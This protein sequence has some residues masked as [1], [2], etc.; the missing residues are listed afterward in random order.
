MKATL[1]K[2]AMAI[3]IA[4]APMF[5]HAQNWSMGGN[6]ISGG[7]SQSSPVWKLGVNSGPGG[8]RLDIVH[9][10]TPRIRVQTGVMILGD[11]SSS[12]LF[13]DFLSGNVG[14]GTANPLARLHVGGTLR[15]DGA[16]TSG[17]N[18]SLSTD[19]N[20]VALRVNNSEALWS[21]GSYFSWGYDAQYNY[22]A[23]GITLGYLPSQMVAPPSGGMLI[24]G[25]LG[26]GDI[27]S[28]FAQLHVGG[29]IIAEKNGA[30]HTMNDIGHKFEKAGTSYELTYDGSNYLMNFTVPAQTNLLIGQGS[31]LKTVEIG[32]LSQPTKKTDLFVYGD[33]SVRQQLNVCG[34][35]TTSEVEVK[36]GWCDYVFEKE[37]SLMTIDELDAYIQKNKHLPNIP[38]ALE[39]EQNGLQIADMERRMMEKIEELSLYIIQLKKQNDV[40]Q[41]EIEQL[42]K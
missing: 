37:Y 6:T 30:K 34:K 41:E 14:V 18:L 28:P 24:K 7:T 1:I 4:T 9:Y 11:I 3:G 16:I 42:K 29:G 38:S 17:G 35:I 15:T 26:I 39:V 31:N 2:S 22:F 10:N 36:S 23:K 27:S 21:N 8:G 32:S 20:G 33:V 12:T 40:L 25:K 5:S 13:M 19:A